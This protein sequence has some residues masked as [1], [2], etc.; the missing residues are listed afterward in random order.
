MENFRPIY[1]PTDDD[2]TYGFAFDIRNV[3]PGPI[4]VKVEDVRVRLGDRT[5][6]GDS[7]TIEFTLP[8]MGPKGISTGGFKKEA[9]S[10]KT[11][12][13]IKAV[14]LYGNPNEQQFSRRY[15]MTMDISLSNEGGG[16]I[17]FGQHNLQE[18]DEPI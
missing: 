11:E 9:V 3:G 10:G 15:T 13:S 12:G 16:P 6:R 17:A 2:L 1:N 18:R 14:F 5:P 7:T 4:K 8:R